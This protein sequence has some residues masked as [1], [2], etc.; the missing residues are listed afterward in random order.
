MSKMHLLQLRQQ[1]NAIYTGSY[2]GTFT[3]DLYCS[4][5]MIFSWRQLVWYYHNSTVVDAGVGF[6]IDSTPLN[7]KS[8]LQELQLWFYNYFRQ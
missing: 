5:I 6:K 4:F 8:E 3:F 7:K 1:M 2:W